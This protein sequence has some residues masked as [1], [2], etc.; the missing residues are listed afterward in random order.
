MTT[1]STRNDPGG[2]DLGKTEPAT[3]KANNTES[4][5]APAAK[6]NPDL[7]AKEQE[8]AKIDEAS[9]KL[10]ATF[11]PQANDI[12]GS[13]AVKPEAL[14]LTSGY[15]SFRSTA[16]GKLTFLQLDPT[17]EQASETLDNQI[18]DG[19]TEEFLFVVP[20]SYSIDRLG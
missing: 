4:S 17:L 2:A 7:N 6:D 5:T 14:K 13:D 18:D 20:V 12:T 8:D 19:E 11:A 16:D 9:N 15:A 3:Q 10:D 1:K